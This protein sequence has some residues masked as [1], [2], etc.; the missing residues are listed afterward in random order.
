MLSEKMKNILLCIFTLFTIVPVTAQEVVDNDLRTWLT[1]LNRLTIN[2]KWS[3][4]NEVHERTNQF[5]SE[6][7]QFLV[8]PSID[9]HL[10]ENAEFSF[11]YSY[12]HMSPANDDIIQ[13]DN[14][15]HNV[16][17]QLNFKFYVGKFEIQ[18]RLRQEHRW[19]GNL[20]NNGSENLVDGTNYSNRFRFRLTI[21]RDIYEFKNKKTRLFVNAFDELWINQNSRLLPTEFTRNWL[22]VG[23]GIT[24]DKNTKLQ[25]GYMGQ[26]EYISINKYSSTPILLATIIKNFKLR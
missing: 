13:L 20:S 23:A 1:L 18:N 6:Q 12:I 14:Y 7:G 10:T 25:L 2:E 15:E 19:V 16:W 4:T 21:S 11:G 24:F 8:R 9:Y 17:E 26:F 3:V 22:Y 5:F